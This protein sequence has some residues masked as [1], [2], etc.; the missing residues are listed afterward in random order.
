MEKTAN[1]FTIG[2]F[3]LASFFALIGF[4][5]WLESPRQEG[6]LARYTVYFTVP[7]GGLEEGAAVRY[8][9]IKVGK[10]EKLRLDD[11][12]ADLVKA[13]IA[14][15]EDTPVRA[16]T[17][18]MLDMQGIAGMTHLELSTEPDDKGEPQ[19]VEGEQYPVLTGSAAPFTRIMN[20][21]E[22]FSDEGFS[23]ITGAATE[24]KHAAESI[25][26]LADQLR[27]DPSQVL[28][29][30]KKKRPQPMQ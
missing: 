9:G 28:H 16:H 12:R 21:F 1:Y 14:V 29:G 8:K 25:R 22:K 13:D 23:E 18:A 24:A 30:P 6:D 7:V 11:D 10:I 17:K 27:A 20:N 15:D 19:Q 26:K 3:V 2:V 4:V 5:I